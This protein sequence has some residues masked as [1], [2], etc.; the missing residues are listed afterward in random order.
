MEPQVFVTGWASVLEALTDVSNTDT[1]TEGADAGF[2]Q[3][4]A[5]L[6]ATFMS[7][8]Q[9]WYVSNSVN[10]VNLNKGWYTM[11]QLASY[12]EKAATLTNNNEVTAAQNAIQP[13]ISKTQAT[14]SEDQNQFQGLIESGTNQAS[15]LDPSHIQTILSALSAILQVFMQEAQLTIQ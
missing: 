12:M 14:I 2:V 1:V 5:N 6:N 13:V 8:T 10:A 11:G 15:Q 9:Q 4:V 7:P 3:T